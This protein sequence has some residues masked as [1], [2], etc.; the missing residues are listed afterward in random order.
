MARS[1]S[2]EDIRE[3]VWYCDP[4]KALGVDGYNL[5]FI[6]KLWDDIGCEFC[7]AMEEFFIS[8]TLPRGSNVMWGTLIHKIKGTSDIREFRP[9]SMVGSIYKVVSK[10]LANR[11]RSVMPKLV[12]ETQSAFMGGRQI[13]DGAL[14]ACEVVH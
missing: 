5:N 9:I 4:S 7:V 8:R 12:G 13:L 11:M 2:R 10:I 6:R 3:A 14:V 1:L